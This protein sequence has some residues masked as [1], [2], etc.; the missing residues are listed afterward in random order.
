MVMDEASC[1]GSSHR[2]LTNAFEGHDDADDKRT[3]CHVF[4]Q[5][6]L[7]TSRHD[8]HPANDETEE[9]TGAYQ[10]RRGKQARRYLAN[11]AADM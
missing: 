10:N 2:P 8:S 3:T 9:N 5:M 7:P 11:D 1:R 4:S 6:V